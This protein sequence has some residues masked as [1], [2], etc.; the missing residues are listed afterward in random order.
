VQLHCSAVTSYIDVVFLDVGGPIYGDRPYYEAYLQAIKEVRPD[1]DE[2]MFWAEFEAARRDQRGPFTAR[3]GGLFV[4]EDLLPDVVER[5]R[6]LWHY[7]PE[8][9]QPDVRASL[10][11]LHQSYRLG[12]LANQQPWIRGVLA[13]DGL[14]M[15]FDVWAIS[16]EVGA[17]K[18]D[19]AIFEH[20]LREAGTG[21][22]RC[23][24]VGDRLDNDVIPARRHGMRGIWLLRGEAPDDPTEEQLAQADAAVR[25]MEELPV[26]LEGLAGNS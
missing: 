21:P 11:T 12:V 10:E 13:R 15:Y 3:L 16:A 8:D 23:A 18:P 26:A 20:A 6:E 2:S 14:G 25:S 4:D 5:G 1:A 7:R 19:P 22:D 24:M 9:L 17:E